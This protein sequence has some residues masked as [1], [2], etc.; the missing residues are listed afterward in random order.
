MP[1]GEEIGKAEDGATR[2]AGTKSKE[3]EGTQAEGTQEPTLRGRIPDM[4][5]KWTCSAGD[6]ELDASCVLLSVPPVV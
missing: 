4:D 5:K 2:S 3:G 6:N 1:H